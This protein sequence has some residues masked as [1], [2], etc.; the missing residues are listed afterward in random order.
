VTA[1]TELERRRRRRAVARAHHPDLGGDPEAF[2]LAWQ[3]L[4]GTAPR[5][6]GDRRTAPARAGATTAGPEV[7]FVRRPRGSARWF[8]WLRPHRDRRFATRRLR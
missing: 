4:E 2:I 8:A 5:Q 3:R 6:G 7:T 1:W